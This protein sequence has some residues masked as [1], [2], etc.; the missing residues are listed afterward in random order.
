M[1]QKVR[2]K[3]FLSRRTVIA[4][5]VGICVVV[6]SC[7]IFPKFRVKSQRNLRNFQSEKT[8]QLKKVVFKNN[9]NFCYEKNS[10]FYFPHIRYSPDIAILEYKTSG[11]QQ[12]IF[13]AI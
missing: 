3:T 8:S 9:F 10:K 4:V 13:A 1:Q 12:E 7:R 2:K 5:T 6:K 11:F